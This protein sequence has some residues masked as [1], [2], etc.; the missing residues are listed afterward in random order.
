MKRI[1]VYRYYHK[2]ENN[3]HLLKFLKH[4]NPGLEIYGLFGGAE[5]QF[6]E[7][8]AYLKDELTH[9]YLIKEKDTEWKWKNSD[10][11]Y[12]IWYNDF[13]HTVDFDVMHAIEWDLIY[14]Q[15][16]DKIFAHVPENSL[17]LTGL[18]PLKK[19]QNEWYWTKHPPCKVEWL[20]MMEYYK[21]QYNYNQQPYGML[22]PGT[23]LPR[24]F[25]E[26]IKNID[27]PAI[28]LDELRLPMWAQVLGFEMTD[29]R[30]YKKWFSKK[31]FLVFNSN[32]QDISLDTIRKELRNPAGRRVFH[33]VRDNLTFDA[34]VSLYNTIP[35]D[36]KKKFSIAQLFRSAFSR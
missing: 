34:L 14:F 8:T 20:Q 29:T 15:P 22:G 31:E 10:M 30:F 12:Q 35:P 27:I 32:A 9:N 3:R 11:T 19:I 36:T 16:L 33:P 23:S 26:T 28:A 7:A 18:I 6:E 5:E 1:V 25:L 17:A 24:K 4:T 2:F 21:K 13:G